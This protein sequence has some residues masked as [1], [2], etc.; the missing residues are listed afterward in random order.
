M[1]RLLLLLLSATVLFAC[2]DGLDDGHIASLEASQSVL[3]AGGGAIFLPAAGIRSNASVSSNGTMGYYWS[4]THN[5]T[6]YAY[7]MTF[8]QYNLSLG[9]VSER[10]C[11]FSVRLVRD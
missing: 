4:S 3:E 11:G 2:T 10:F 6:A 1:K 9:N 8:S 7:S 5:E